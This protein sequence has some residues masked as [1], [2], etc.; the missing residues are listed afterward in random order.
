MKS[1]VQLLRAKSNSTPE[2]LLST[3]TIILNSCACLKIDSK[4]IITKFSQKNNKYSLSIAFNKPLGQVCIFRKFDYCARTKESNFLNVC[5]RSSS[6]SNA[7]KAEV[8]TD[9]ALGEIN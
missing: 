1:E 5:T 7:T 3:R 4:A 2:T 6:L 9:S 8:V